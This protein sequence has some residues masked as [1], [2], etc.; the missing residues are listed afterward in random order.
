MIAHAARESRGLPFAHASF[1]FFRHEIKRGDRIMSRVFGNKIVAW[2]LVMNSRSEL[3]RRSIVEEF[4]QL[5]ARSL[6]SGRVSPNTADFAIYCV[7]QFL[8]EFDSF[9]AN[10]D[11]HEL[12]FPR[13]DF[14][15]PDG[16]NVQRRSE[17][18]VCIHG[19]SCWN[20]A[21]N[22]DPR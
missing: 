13:S 11:I 21:R 6:R 17:S 2:K 1:N 12:H 7:A 14:Q 15:F 18:D 10:E 3:V 5:H 19:H 8:G 9:R 16:V 4:V 20:Q 22:S